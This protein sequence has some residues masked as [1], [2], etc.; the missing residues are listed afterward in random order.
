MISKLALWLALVLWASFTTAQGYDGN[1]QNPAN[2]DWTI[3]IAVNGQDSVLREE[4]TATGGWAYSTYVRAWGSI[5]WVKNGVPLIDPNGVP[6][7]LIAPVQQVGR[8]GSQLDMWSQGTVTCRIRWKNPYNPAPA[9]VRLKVLA[10]AR[11]GAT[12]TQGTAY[13]CSNGLDTAFHYGEE[14]SPG[15]LESISQ[16]DPALRTISVDAQGY[17]TF[18]LSKAAHV[19]STPSSGAIWADAKGGSLEIEPRSAWIG[20]LGRVP[21]RKVIL[22]APGIWTVT[23]LNGQTVQTQYTDAGSE[24]VPISYPST[25]SNSAVWP[26]AFPVKARENVQFDEPGYAGYI[27]PSSFQPDTLT[28]IAAVTQ[29]QVPTAAYTWESDFG[30]SGG[31]LPLASAPHWQ[32]SDFQVAYSQYAVQTIY[33][34]YVNPFFTA[35]LPGYP[36]YDLQAA[37]TVGDQIRFT[38]R[39]SDGLTAVCE[40]T[41]Q[42]HQPVEMQDRLGP[43]IDDR[44]SAP[45]ETIP[46][47]SGPW[48]DPSADAVDALAQP[49][50]AWLKYVG[51]AAKLAWKYASAL[52]EAKLLLGIISE[53][54]DLF[55]LW[56]E[57]EADTRIVTREP[58]GE[59]EV[60]PGAMAPVT[61]ANIRDFYWQLQGRPRDHF[62]GQIVDVYDLD[63]FRERGVVEDRR[64]DGLLDAPRRHRFWYKHGPVGGDGPIPPPTGGGN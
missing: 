11:A 24:P 6:I 45:W 18:V 36:Y 60:T 13:S 28:Y 17:A 53:V 26:I 33:H 16:Y 14:I 48:A 57:V 31:T 1:P 20:I 59:Y 27:T 43:V 37:D 58:F 55:D 40:R 30:G 50:E 34:K 2:W 10:S 42:V 44:L 52:P 62:F 15:C 3:P 5:I 25:T 22:Q 29:D 54:L 41:L 7:D 39:W 19:T 49:Y 12:S 4:Q 9:E 63:G 23:K 61:S 21:K 51:N 64:R 32:I 38:Y 56:P 35:D 47:L 46:F 8:P